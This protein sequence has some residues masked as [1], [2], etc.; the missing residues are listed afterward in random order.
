MY[1]TGLFRGEIFYLVSLVKCGEHVLATNLISTEF[2]SKNLNFTK[3]SQTCH[4]QTQKTQRPY[5]YR[6][7]ETGLSI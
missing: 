6:P 3:I 1:L 2:S 5:I 7:E 4:I